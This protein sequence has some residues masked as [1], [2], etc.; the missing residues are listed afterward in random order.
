MQ[1]RIF[2]QRF[3][4]REESV[5]S[6]HAA[7]QR[8]VGQCSFCPY[9]TDALQV[10]MVLYS[11]RCSVCFLSFGTPSHPPPVPPH[12]AISWRLSHIQRGGRKENSKVARLK[13]HL[14]K[15][16]F[17]GIGENKD[18]SNRDRP[19][20]KTPS[21]ASGGKTAGREL[22]P[23][24]SLGL[25]SPTNG[26]AGI[27]ARLTPPS[28]RRL[29]VKGLA[30]TMSASGSHVDSAATALSCLSPRRMRSSLSGRRL[31]VWAF[32]SGGDLNV[33]SSGVEGTWQ[34]PLE[35]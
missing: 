29:S 4:D 13:R 12:L 1:P 28:G 25:N 27:A 6:N 24:A 15:L 35:T 10:T 3:Y 22:I 21:V 2:G 5:K 19:S 18:S 30:A 9:V 17:K 16:G 14:E 23:A 26:Y 7:I 31:S 34:V 8:F 33:A 11:S 20:S 32:G